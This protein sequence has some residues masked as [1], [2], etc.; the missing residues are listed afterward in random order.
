MNAFDCLVTIL[1][2]ISGV[3]SPFLHPSGKLSPKIDFKKKP[4]KTIDPFVE[5]EYQKVSYKEFFD[6]DTNLITYVHTLVGFAIEKQKDAVIIHEDHQ[7]YLFDELFYITD[8]QGTRIGK[9][10]KLVYHFQNEDQFRKIYFE[11]RPRTY[12]VN[13]ETIAQNIIPAALKIT[14][15]QFDYEGK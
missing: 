7:P 1:S 5:K 3:N 8:T 14:W 2:T 10:K 13:M 12:C 4:A 6:H 9:Y 15:Q 11:Y